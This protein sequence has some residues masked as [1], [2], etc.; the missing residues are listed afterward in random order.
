[1]NICNR[2]RI[3]RQNESF[4]NNKYSGPF[5]E[6]EEGYIH[7]RFS[8]KPDS[9]NQMLLWLY[10][11]NFYS[12]CGQRH[13]GGI[14]IRIQNTNARSSQTQFGEWPHMC[15]VL[16]RTPIAGVEQILYVCGGSLIAP[17]VVLTAAHCVE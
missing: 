11:I 7:R 17:N 15:A 4:F 8:R 16:N 2:K 3:G 9:R 1:M 14:G 12:R 13:R 10:L 5:Y 6:S